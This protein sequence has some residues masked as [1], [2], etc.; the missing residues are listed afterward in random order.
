MGKEGK[1]LK[2]CSTST[3]VEASDRKSR[4]PLE[5]AETELQNL[6]TQV[7]PQKRKKK[8]EIKEMKKLRKSFQEMTETMKNLQEFFLGRADLPGITMKEEAPEEPKGEMEGSAEYECCFETEDSDANVDHAV[9]VVGIDTCLA[10]EDIKS[11]LRKHFESGGCQVSRIFVPIEC[12]TGVPL[13]SAFILV[14]D[15]QKALRCR[16]AYMGKSVFLVLLAEDQEFSVTFPNF[17]GC[18][19]CPLFRMKHRQRNWLARR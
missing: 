8:Y 4:K 19:K 10:R 3:D 18:P 7:N 13:G 14:D 16:G 15:K 2:R 17:R 12:Q 9:L 5:K 1:G 6:E 11:A